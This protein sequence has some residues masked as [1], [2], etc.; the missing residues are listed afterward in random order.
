[1]L[2]E[3]ID[4]VEVAQDRGH[5]SNAVKFSGLYNRQVLA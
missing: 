4:W 1:M 5:M 3:D 2:C